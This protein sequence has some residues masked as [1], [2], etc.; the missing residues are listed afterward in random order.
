MRHSALNQQN[1]Q[2]KNR[3]LYF[4]LGLLST[5][6]RLEEQLSKLPAE[7]T[8]DVEA[9]AQN[10]DFLYLCLGLMF[11]SQ[12]LQ[13]RLKLEYDRTTVSDVSPSQHNPD[14]LNGA[15]Y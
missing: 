9:H 10:D 14:A 2:L 4:L 13:A 11:F 8:S 3:S 12:D 5:S 7:A 6:Q 15:L 1:S